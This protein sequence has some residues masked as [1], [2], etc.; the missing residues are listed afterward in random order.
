MIALRAAR[1]YRAEPAAFPASLFVIEG[2]TAAVNATPL[3]DDL[4]VRPIGGDHRS[5]IELPHVTVVGDRIRALR[6]TADR[7]PDPERRGVTTA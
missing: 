4:D 1:R 7:P 2:S 3:V 5:C 6:T